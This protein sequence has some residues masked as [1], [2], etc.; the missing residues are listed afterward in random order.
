MKLLLVLV[1]SV[2]RFVQP[3]A[4]GICD[5]ELLSKENIKHDNVTSNSQRAFRPSTMA[6]RA[7]EPSTMAQHAAEV[8]SRPPEMPSLCF[9][10]AA[11]RRKEDTITEDEYLQ[12]IVAHCT[13]VRHG[14]NQLCNG[15]T[16]DIPD[17]GN[18]SF[19]FLHSWKHYFAS[20]VIE[21]DHFAGKVAEFIASYVDEKDNP[22]YGMDIELRYTLSFSN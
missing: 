16:S 19:N 21:V 7:V 22:V 10:D 8:S 13:G 1:E 11:V 3:S 20:N 17:N 14:K 9:Y 18:E 4:T 2:E 5:I 6:Q 15:D 12:A